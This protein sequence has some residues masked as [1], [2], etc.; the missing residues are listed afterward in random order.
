MRIARRDDHPALAMWLAEQAEPSDVV[1]RDGTAAVFLGPVAAARLTGQTLDAR[2]NEAGLRVLPA[3]L[4]PDR[5][6]AWRA[7]RVASCPAE[8]RSREAADGGE[9]YR[10]SGDDRYLSD[11]T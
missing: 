7:G 9:L 3:R 4:S 11:R 1:L 8:R 10:R 5:P 2:T 6:A